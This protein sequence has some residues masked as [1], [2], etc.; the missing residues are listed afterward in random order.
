MDI[1][2]QFEQEFTRLVYNLK[3]INTEFRTGYDKEGEAY[4][5]PIKDSDNSK[6]TNKNILQYEKNNHKLDYEKGMAFDSDGKTIFEISSN[7]SDEIEIDDNTLSKL[8]GN[9][10]SH[11]HPSGNTF[12]KD[13]LVTGFLRGK[14]KEIRAT[15]PQGITFILRPNENNTELLTKKLVAEY[16]QVLLRAIRQFKEK[17]TR[18]IRA[19]IM[20]LDEYNSNSYNMF[21]PYRHNKLDKF[22][23]EHAGDYGFTYKK[24]K[25]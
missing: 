13:D 12:S 17:C 1:R 11:N 3:A 6:E 25:I 16:Q 9:I 2:E 14:A 7:R 19:G 10:F 20:T 4:V 5:Y 18:E 24:E 15:T 22:L 23:E 21:K 8:K